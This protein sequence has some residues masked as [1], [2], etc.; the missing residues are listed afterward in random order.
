[1]L[2]L[3]SPVSLAAVVIDGGGD[4]IVST[5]LF[6]SNET[7]PIAKQRFDMENTQVYFGSS[8]GSICPLCAYFLSEFH[9]MPWWWIV[10]GSLIH[11]QMLINSFGPSPA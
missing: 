10:R 11:L 8:D 6:L 3:S 2:H 4:I 7:S 1:M 9:V 5:E